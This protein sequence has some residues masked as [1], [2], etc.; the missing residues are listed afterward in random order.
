MANA[1]SSHGFIVNPENFNKK[2]TCTERE[3]LLVI[4]VR[5]LHI[6]DILLLHI[7]IDFTL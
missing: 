6:L 5:Y 7:L 4:S 1:L 3:V 2:A